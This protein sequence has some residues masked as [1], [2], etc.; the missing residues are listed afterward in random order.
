MQSAELLIFAFFAFF[1][2]KGR[3]VGPLQFGLRH[4]I[5]VAYFAYFAWFAVEKSG[6]D[7]LRSK[8]ASV[9]ANAM[10]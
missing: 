8:A 2:V 4:V 6:F 5:G 3:A 1:A 9:V 10:T 7:G